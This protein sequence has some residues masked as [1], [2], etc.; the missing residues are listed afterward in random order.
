MS[1]Q[2]NN[3]DRETRFL[4]NLALGYSIRKAGTKAGYSQSYAD[5]TLSRRLLDPKF[6]AKM[7]AYCDKMPEARQVL[8]KLRLGK[9][10]RIEEQILDKALTCDDYA[11]RPVVS[12]TMERE[13]KLTGLLQDDHAKPVMVQINLAMIQNKQESDLDVVTVKQIDHDTGTDTEDKPR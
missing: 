4:E 9:V 6:I 5:S 8:A 1:K 10:A 12:K 13:Y 11:T 7:Q 3:G 2:T